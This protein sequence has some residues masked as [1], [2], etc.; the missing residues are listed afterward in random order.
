[1]TRATALQVDPANTEQAQ[2]W[3][4]DEGA[5]WAQNAERFDRAL[6]AYRERFLAAAGIGRA[7]RVLD[8][9]CGTG[10]TTRDA[11]R[12]AADGFAL[13]VDL[14]RRM[15]ELGRR[16]AAGQGIGNALFEQA[17]AQIHPFPAAGFD[18][19]ISR[20]GTMFFGDPSAAFANIARAIR[21]GGRL[22]LLVWQGPEANEWIRELAG[23]LAAGRDLPTP[24]A[25]CPG[26]FAQASPEAVRAVLDAAGF[27]R[28]E[29]D[30]LRRPM[31]FGSDA[32]DACAFVLG[33]MGWM[34]QDLD[35]AGRGRA[36]RN[37]RATLNRHD[38]GPGVFYESA[39]WIITATR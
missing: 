23:A 37:L 7:D 27:S 34:I 1:M 15:I 3:D 9:G 21:P 8:I 12:A 36:L 2:A 14:S 18:V 24:P 19:A 26:P 13:G 35:D 30:G 25:G 10:Q 11:A 4:G 16:L 29:L 17:D 38:T 31:W 20:T 22:A 6:G 5:Y 32:E 39:T 33:L 28:I